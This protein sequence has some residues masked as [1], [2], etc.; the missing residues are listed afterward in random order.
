SAP[1]AP[2]APVANES[3]PVQA[4]AASSTVEGGDLSSRLL[5]AQPP[6]YPVESRRAHEQGTVQLLV[7]VGTDGRVSEIS[8][9][10]SSGSDRLDKAA[11][12]A[13]R[14]WRW[15]PTLR[16]GVAVLV[17]GIVTIP[18]VLRSGPVHTG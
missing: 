8:L 7:L 6:S 17:R 16:G 9:A 18:F 13:V 10:S 3:A 11:L 14:H 2:A 4:A 12:R 5:A 15:M 1:P